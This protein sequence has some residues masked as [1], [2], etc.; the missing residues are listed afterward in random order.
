VHVQ[1]LIPYDYV[2]LAVAGFGMTAVDFLF[3]SQEERAF[4]T[5][6]KLVMALSRPGCH[7]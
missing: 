2:Y 7:S 4:A 3:S 1:V 5:Y 6:R